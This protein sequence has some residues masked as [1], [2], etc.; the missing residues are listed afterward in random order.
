MNHEPGPAE[1]WIT[2]LGENGPLCGLAIETLGTNVDLDLLSKTLSDISKEEG[3]GPMLN[4]S[5][6]TDGRRWNNAKLMRDVLTALG[7]LVRAEQKRQ[8]E[9]QDGKEQPY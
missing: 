8:A 7:G 9:W 4:P 3:I 5:A 2:F 1:F 6:Y